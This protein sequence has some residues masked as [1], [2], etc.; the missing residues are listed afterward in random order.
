MADAPGGRMPAIVPI[1]FDGGVPHAQ[2]TV[3][4]DELAREF[5]TG[6]IVLQHG[7]QPV[8]VAI[9]V[10]QSS[11]FSHVGMVLRPEDLGIE[12]VPEGEWLYLESNTLTNLKDWISGDIKKGGGPMAVLL[13]ERLKTNLAQEKNLGMA[14]RKLAFGWGEE[15]LANL[16]TYVEKVKDMKFDDSEL[17]AMI[18]L[19]NWISGRVANEPNESAYMFCS[20]LVAGCYRAAGMLPE[21]WVPNAY[22]PQD[23][24]GNGRVALLGGSAL[25]PEVWID[26]DSLRD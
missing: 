11:F 4:Y 14:W 3:S 23:F 24:S 8:S 22:T 19:K 18:I 10:L 2:W 25:G 15:P 21:R 6:D 1:V 7:V 16:R 20:E 9:S 26:P 17:C 13:R 5:Q 12:G